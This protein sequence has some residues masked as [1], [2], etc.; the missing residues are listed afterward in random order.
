MD[1][2]ARFSGVIQRLE[3]NGHRLTLAAISQGQEVSLYR[4]G[5]CYDDGNPCLNNGTCLPVLDTFKCVCSHKTTGETCEIGEFFK[6][7]FSK[8]P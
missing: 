4:K 6:I 1:E 5:A 8:Y 7:I 2:T 3:V